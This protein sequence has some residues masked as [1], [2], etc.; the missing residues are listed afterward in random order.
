MRTTTSTKRG[1]QYW[2]RLLSVGLFGGI[3]LGYVIFIAIYVE[4]I[5][6]PVPSSVCC[7]TGRDVNFTYE[8]VTFTSED[9]VTLSGWYIPSGN[10]AAVILL[11]GYGANR[12][13]MITRAEFFARHKYGVLLYDL[14]GHGESGG[15]LRSYGWLDVK[16]VTAGLGFLQSREEID[17]NRIGIFGFSVGGQIA[18]RAAAQHELLKAVV[19]DGPS[20][21]RTEDAPLPTSLF[22]EVSHTIAW[23]VDRVLEWRTGVTAPPGV[24]AVIGEIG[25]RPILLIA[26]GQDATEVHIAKHYYE[27]AYDPKALWQIP[28]AGHGGGLLARPDEY[29]QRVIRFFSESLLESQ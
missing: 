20:L 28:E 3:I 2:L 1:W 19:A 27:Q 25:S 12:L 5:V 21:A 24:E 9:N 10:R 29:E 4:V 6:R 18:L 16:D 11:H 13:E 7:L 14:R 26:T 8:T 22:E 17:P 23:V 15:N